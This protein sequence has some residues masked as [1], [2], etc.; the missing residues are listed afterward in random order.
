MSATRE[1]RAEG[2]DE[3]TSDRAAV[4]GCVRD[5]TGFEGLV[6]WGASTARMFSRAEAYTRAMSTGPPRSPYIVSRAYDCAFFLAPPALALALGVALA[7]MSLASQPR[8]LGGQR[9]SLQELALGTLVHA[10]L[11]AVF[12]R[13]HGNP[14]VFRRHRARF[15]LAPL[16]LFTAIVSS[17]TFAIAALVV[18]TFWDVYHSGAQTFGLARI[19][20]RNAGNDL[21]AGRW[22]DFGLQQVLYAG[23]V[24]AGATTL[25]HFEPFLRFEAVGLDRLARVP[26]AID[27]VHRAMALVLLGLGALYL[28][29][30][31][32]SYWRLA[33]RGHRI[34]APKVFLMVS[35]GACSIVAWGF[36]PFAQAFFIMNLFHAVQ[37]LALVWSSE[38]RR[39]FSPSRR[40]V[41]FVLLASL[42]GAYGVLGMLA[43]N[44]QQSLGVGLWSVALTI[45]IVHYWYDGFIWSVARNEI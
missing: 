34:S 44:T 18:A 35:T 40:R 10:H 25:D 3:A 9:L 45:S 4:S 1:Q 13:S 32:A 6:S 12:L 31:V 8:A 30:Y 16:V 19:Y 29:F 17:P 15:L 41:G 24:L 7:R 11:V 28:V 42:L 2:A 14:A 39:I 37:Y 22:L 36:N 33:R 43:D 20:D 5:G 23:P 27:S 38:G 21:R 26:S